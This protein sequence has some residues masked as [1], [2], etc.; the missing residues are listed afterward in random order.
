[1]KSNLN[2]KILK[3]CISEICIQVGFERISEQSLNILADV[4]KHYISQI[5]LKLNKAI[6]PNVYFQ[7]G[8][9]F[10]IDN[11]LISE[12]YRERELS[13]FLKSQIALRKYLG[14]Q[15]SSKSLLHYFK[16]LPND[17]IFTG[18]TRNNSNEIDPEPNLKSSF[19]TET[20]DKDEEFKNFL[21]HC[22][23]ESF[24]KRKITESEFDFLNI[25]EDP[26]KKKFIFDQTNF[27][28]LDRVEN[29]PIEVY[30]DLE[31]IF[32]AFPKLSRRKVFKNIE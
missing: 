18:I 23:P 3:L 29:R 10:C 30:N 31:D 14:D 7:H 24:R 27:L 26:P 32:N 17:Q 5:S 9:R 11:F 15:G 20:I 28:K 8:S 25:L 16:I 19:V 6:G 1:M 22:N 2:I 4:L 21:K 12:S 13:S